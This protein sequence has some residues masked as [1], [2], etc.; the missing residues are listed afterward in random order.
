MARIKK[1]FKEKEIPAQF[2]CSYCKGDMR[3]YHNPKFKP[4]E[5]NNYHPGCSGN[6]SGAGIIVVNAQ[7]NGS[8][9]N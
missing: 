3:F 1:T 5:C 9:I 7:Y 2:K 8:I 6:K 4:C